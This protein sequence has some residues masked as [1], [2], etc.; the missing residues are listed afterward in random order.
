MHFLSD[1]LGTS[2]DQLTI[3]HHE[4]A[5]IYLW[6][7]MGSTGRVCFGLESFR[8]MD[9]AVWVI[10]IVEHKEK[11]QFLAL[12]NVVENNEQDMEFMLSFAH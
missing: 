12:I 9:Y 3:R 10:E 7:R 5:M 11:Y 2:G 8:T 4:C 1:A 6:T